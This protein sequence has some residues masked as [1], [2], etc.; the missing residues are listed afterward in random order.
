[1][2]FFNE[3][4]GLRGDIRYFRA[5]T[6]DNPGSGVDFDLDR[7]RLLEVGR[8]RSVPVLNQWLQASDSGL[9]EPEV[10]G[11]KPAVSQSRSDFLQIIHERAHRFPARV[12]VGLPE[13]RGGMNGRRHERRKC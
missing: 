10:R 2:A 1:M 13:N 8:R 11:R 7:L 6:D 4:V 3:H 5:L 12:R 9:R